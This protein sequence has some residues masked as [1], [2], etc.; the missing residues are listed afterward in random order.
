MHYTSTILMTEFVTH[1]VKRFIV[2]RPENFSHTPG[3]GV[4]LVINQSQ[5]KEEEGRPF[6]PTS[7]P[8]DRV[9][10]FTIK[11]YPDHH[12]VTEKLHSLKPGE[13]IFLSAPFGTIRY[14]GPGVFIAAGAGI[15]PF[16]G[17]CRQLASENQSAGHQLLYANKTKNDII[18]EKELRH[19][20]G[21]D[22]LFIL[23]RES[24][25]GFPQ[26]RITRELLQEVIADSNRYFY[27]CG[28]E[29]FVNDMN[30]ALESLGAKAESLVFEE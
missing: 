30:A 4:E 26:G 23:S 13:E 12:G 28:P 24:A 19:F 3:Q 2:S 9:L 5:W 10:E 20:F 14:K 22:S 1:D 18:C 27:V 8:H 11:R 6:T 17:I 29:G 21:A 25:A 15:T 7:L 16:L